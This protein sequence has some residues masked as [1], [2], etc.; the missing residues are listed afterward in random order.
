M[1]TAWRIAATAVA[2][3]LACTALAV[4]AAAADRP[5][6]RVFA[7][8]LLGANETAGGDTDGV[9]VA[10]VT[11]NT[12]QSKVCYV[13]AAARLD[14][15]V[16]GHI[17]HAPAG[18]N[19]PVVI[20]FEPLVNGFVAACTTVAKDLAVDLARNPDQYYANLHTTVFPAGAVRGQLP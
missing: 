2:A 4:P 19:G 20:P 8:I 14:T 9:A 7:T 17:H 16:A 15:I 18:V 5:T 3:S 13:V 10:V 11:V 12:A 6:V 1:R